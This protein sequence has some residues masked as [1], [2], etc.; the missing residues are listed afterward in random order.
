MIALCGSSDSDQALVAV[1]LGLVDLDDTAA[2]LSDLI[3]L[4]ASLANDSSN[5]IIWNED[6][7][8][9]WLT[10]NN[11]RG[12]A[13]G[14]WL[15]LSKATMVW[16]LWLLGSDASITSNCGRSTI[17]HWYSWLGLWGLTMGS[18][19]LAVA[20]AR[21]RVSTAIVAAVVGM[22]IISSGRLG[23]IRHNLHTTRN[24]T[25]RTSTSRSVSGSCRATKSLGE[26][27]EERAT[28]IVCSNVDGVRNT[29]ND[30]RTLGRE[31]EARVGS[32]ETGT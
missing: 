28:N 12:W 8:G 11:R 9:Q 29:K 2:K 13:T 16:L 4:G 18:I 6:L 19:W 22:S 17:V 20:V 15:R 7:L 1:I 3:D 31:W 26:L 14:A 25:S 27:F 21:S 24:N 10:R 32:I 5:H 30:Q 23:N